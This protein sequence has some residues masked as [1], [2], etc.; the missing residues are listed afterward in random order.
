MVSLSNPSAD[1]VG[2]LYHPSTSSGQLLLLFLNDIIINN[3]A[4]HGQQFCITDYRDI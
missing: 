1:G 2:L 4:Y 3:S